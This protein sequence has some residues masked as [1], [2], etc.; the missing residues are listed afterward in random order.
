[1]MSLFFAMGFSIISMIALAHRPDMAW[2]SYYCGLMLICSGFALSYIS[3]SAI[4]FV[5]VTLVAA[6]FFVA[7]GI[8]GL[9]KE[10]TWPLLL[11]NCYFLCSMTLAGV[12]IAAIR[13]RH[14]RELFLLRQAL[15]RDIELTK[16]AKRQSDYIADHDMLTEMPNRICFMRQLEAAIARAHE[17]HKT[18]AVLFLDLNGFKPINDRLGHEV[19]DK[20]LK[21]VAQRITSCVRANDLIARMGGDEFVV[22]VELDYFNILSAVERLQRELEKAIASPMGI[23]GGTLSVEASV[24]TARYPFDAEEA[25]KLIRCADR[26]MYEAKRKSK[27]QWSETVAAADSANPHST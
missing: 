7:V 6:Y 5:A 25:D 11:M 12:I 21:I 22:A 1:M 13:D 3:L 17:Q 14:T 15:H 19:G 23:E 9:W 4:I 10:P 16:E 26:R 20:V 27:D 2:S 8:Q 24:G 18:I